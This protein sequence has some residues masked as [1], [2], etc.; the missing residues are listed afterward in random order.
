VLVPSAGRAAAAS[1]GADEPENRM[2][3]AERRDSRDP[4]AT[5]PRLNR[6]GR[7]EPPAT[8]ANAGQITAPNQAPD[9]GSRHAERPACFLHGDHVDVHATNRIMI[10]SLSQSYHTPHERLPPPKFGGP[11]F[12]FAQASGLVGGSP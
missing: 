2:V 9:R 4:I 3:A 12:G 8:S 1:A 5:R 7:N 11:S 10:I 6:G